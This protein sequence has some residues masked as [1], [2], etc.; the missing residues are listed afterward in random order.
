M[1]PQPALST[2]G[3]PTRSQLAEQ[4]AQSQACPLQ[5]R[6]PPV[7]LDKTYVSESL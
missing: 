2:L 1:Y 4:H 7:S 6:D 5:S 3:S